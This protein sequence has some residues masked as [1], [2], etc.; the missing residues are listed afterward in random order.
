MKTVTPT[1]L[2]RELFGCVEEVLHGR[3]IRVAARHGNAV[4]VSE[5]VF[6]GRR[7]ASGSRI[8]G[9]IVGDLT[10]ADEALRAHVAWPS[11]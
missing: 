4:L 11:E 5:K 3:T 9:R 8:E 6:R 7:R 1:A 2:R 10:R